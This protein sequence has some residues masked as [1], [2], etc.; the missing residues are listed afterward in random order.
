MLCKYKDSFGK[1]GQGVHSIRIFNIAVVDVAMTF[2]LALV[3]NLIFPQSNY[4]VILLF[5]F[6]LGIILH[7]LFCVETTVDKALFGN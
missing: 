7:R 4:F 3:I 2:V 6:M 5:L 1:P